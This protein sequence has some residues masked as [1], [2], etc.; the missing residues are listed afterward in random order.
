M[1]SEMQSKKWHT[2]SLVARVQ[3]LS[4][5]GSSAFLF[6]HVSTFLVRCQFAENTSSNALDIFNLVVQ[7][8]QSGTQMTN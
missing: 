3:K 4:E 6:D 5:R 2:N 1:S 7:Q 8:L